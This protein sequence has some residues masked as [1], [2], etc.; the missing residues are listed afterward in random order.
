MLKLDNITVVCVT[1]V[2]IQES[3]DALVETAKH[4]QYS[5]IKLITHRDGTGNLPDV[6]TGI[7]VEECPKLDYKGY[8]EYIIY[9]LHK[10]IDS[11]FALIINWDGFITNPKQWDSKFLDYDY[12]GALWTVDH[13]YKDINDRDIFVGNGGFSLRSKKLL[14]LASKIDIPWTVREDKYWQEDAI[15]SVM[16]R[17]IY[18]AH[19][20]RW[21]PKHIA[22][23]FSQEYHRE[24]I[25]ENVGVTS[26]GFHGKIGLE[27]FKSR[28]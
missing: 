13:K 9:D 1:S 2:R 20:L 11:E 3:I 8:S 18:E 22:A 6:P 14:E 4:G 21:A 5:S 25:P 26:L 12:I 23:K 19:G 28:V 24:D 27:R 17:H 10:H 15:I 16:N 7:I